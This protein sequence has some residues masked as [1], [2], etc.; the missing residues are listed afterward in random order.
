MDSYKRRSVS[1]KMIV[2]GLII[3]MIGDI[4]MGQSE[5]GLHVD[6]VDPKVLILGANQSGKSSLINVL[7]GCD[8]DDMIG[9]TCD[10]TTCPKKRG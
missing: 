10:F 5:T 4:T 8:K 7:Y 6:P 3:A 9:D 1:S 2:F